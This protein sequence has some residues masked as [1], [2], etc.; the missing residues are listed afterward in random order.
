MQLTQFESLIGF[1]Q[2]QLAK[3]IQ[4]LTFLNRTYVDSIDIFRKSLEQKQAKVEGATRATY[5][6]LG[7][8]V[9]EIS[10][11]I[12]KLQSIHASVREALLH[13]K[14][15]KLA[16]RRDFEIV[17]KIMK[18]YL[19]GSDATRMALI[20]N[21]E[22]A[23]IFDWTQFYRTALKN[24]EAGIEP[25]FYKQLAATINI[26]LTNRYK[27]EVAPP[28]YTQNKLAE[29]VPIER[30]DETEVSP[31]NWDKLTERVRVS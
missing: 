12:E 19:F 8:T 6:L 4:L 1:Y 20:D 30:I 11:I 23:G 22:P 18:P 10:A 26:Y 28:V 3:L 9:G 16:Q 15:A 2:Y 21:L 5:E 17:V 7:N 27:G 31:I 13:P 25:D 14:G 29:L 24:A